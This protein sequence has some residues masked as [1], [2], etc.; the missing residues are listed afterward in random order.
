LGDSVDNFAVL[1]VAVPALF[2]DQRL[3]A[4]A[5]DADPD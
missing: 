3:V 5:A 2:I 4:H 1:G